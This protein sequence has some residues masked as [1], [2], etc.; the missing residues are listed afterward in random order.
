[1]ETGCDLSKVNAK[2]WIKQLGPRAILLMQGG[3]DTTISR[4]SG[5]LLYAA[6]QGP[7]DLWFDPSTGHAKFSTN[8]PAY[9][10]RLSALFDRA[11]RSGPEAHP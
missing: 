2:V 3:A 1:V 9:E 7:K 5:E 11:L 4:Q 8:M 6:A 10:Q